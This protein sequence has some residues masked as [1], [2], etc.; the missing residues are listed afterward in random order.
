[1]WEGWQQAVASTFYELLYLFVST[2][3]SG[4]HLIIPSI[5][6]PH[7]ITLAHTGTLHLAGPFCRLRW[8]F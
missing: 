4:H 1:M 5:S 3:V 7:L 2:S 8:D 6:G